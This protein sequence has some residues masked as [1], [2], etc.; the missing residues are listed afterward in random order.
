MKPYKYVG[1]K[2][3][4]A[5][6]ELKG[7]RVHLP[8]FLWALGHPWQSLGPCRTS[9]LGVKWILLAC[10]HSFPILP[11]RL[12]AWL[13]TTTG[14]RCSHK[15]KMWMRTSPRKTS[16]GREMR[17]RLQT[18]VCHL[19]L[20]HVARLPVAQNSL[21]EASLGPHLVNCNH[22]PVGFPRPLPWPPHL[23]TALALFFLKLL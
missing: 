6:W 12:R 10:P 3:S 23:E 11:R 20:S 2:C 14:L 16:E 17:Y 21:T 22:K 15:E 19:P 9:R 18:A 7:L 1:S 5:V 4:I 13:G 8:P